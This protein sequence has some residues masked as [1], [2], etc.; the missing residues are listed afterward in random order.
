MDGIPLM[1][2]KKQARNP[3]NQ[4]FLACEDNIEQEKRP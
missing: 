3:N 2:L 4:D 1:F